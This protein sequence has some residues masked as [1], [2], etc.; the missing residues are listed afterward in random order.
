MTMR[1]LYVING[2]GAGGAERSLAEML[3]RLADQGVDPLVLCLYHRQEGVEETVRA[4]GLDVRFLPETRLPSR[5]VTL[6]GIIR[7]ERPDLIHTTLFESNAAGRLASIGVRVPLLTSLV[8]TPYERVRLKDPNISARALRSVRVVDGWTSR[9]LTAHFHAITNAVKV[10]AV[11]DL[12]VP[13]ERVTV[14]ERGRDP[15]RLGVASPERRRRSRQ[16][17][18]I[19]DDDT[20]IV[21]AGRQEYQKGQVF[22]IEAVKALLGHHPRTVL[23]VAGRAGHATPDLLRAGADLES[24]GRLR[25][26]GHRDDLPEVLAAGDVF[27]FPSL[28]EGLGGSVIEAMALGLPVVAS[29]IPALREVLEEGRNAQLVASGSAEALAS[30]LQSLLDDPE[31]MQRFGRRSRERF[32]ER[33]TIGRSTSRMVHLYRRIIDGRPAGTGAVCE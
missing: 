15:A 6:R 9:H 28:F 18:D 12:G 23:L 17:L 27:A 7:A 4:S 13:A 26:L 25:F 22:L 21:T 31:R 16:A 19:D 5:A 2:L 8:N 14:V 1:V 11:R 3:P 32:E 33:F 30:A 24:A 10:A 29:D 20:V